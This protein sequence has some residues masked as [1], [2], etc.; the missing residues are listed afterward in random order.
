MPELITHARMERIMLGGTKISVAVYVD[1]S[2][3]QWVVRDSEGK[4]WILPPAENPWEHRQPFFPTE[5]TELEPVP[6]HYKSLIGL[7]Y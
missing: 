5:E 2:R 4:L 3:Q 1:R 6:G 7:P